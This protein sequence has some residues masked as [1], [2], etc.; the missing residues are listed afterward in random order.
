MINN[1]N[2]L[3]TPKVDTEEEIML[4]PISQRFSMTYG[5]KES[6][7]I[8]PIEFELMDLIGCDRGTVH[9]KAIMTLWN[10]MV[11]AKMPLVI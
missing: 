4:Q 6:K 9:K 2:V 11:K 3:I 7:V 8:V 5:K 1:D 10:Q